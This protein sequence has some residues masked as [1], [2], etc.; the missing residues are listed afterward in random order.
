MG[1]GGN[2]LDVRKMEPHVISVR[3]KGEFVCCVK[4]QHNCVLNKTDSHYIVD[5]QLWKQ[6]ETAFFLNFYNLFPQ[7]LSMVYQNDLYEIID[8]I[9]KFK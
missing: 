6:Y 8:I 1:Y 2:R 3:E 9:N 5:K 7:M 4:R